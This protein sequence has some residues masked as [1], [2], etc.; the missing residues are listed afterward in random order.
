MTAFKKRGITDAIKIVLPV[1][2]ML[3]TK[4]GVDLEIEIG[5]YY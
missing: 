3:Q 1:K 4:N 2:V 5:E